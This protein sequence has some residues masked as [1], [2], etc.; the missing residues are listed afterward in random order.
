L[1]PSG[2]NF[3]SEFFSFF[4]YYQEMIKELGELA[5]YAGKS[6]QDIYFDIADCASAGRE[7]L[8]NLCSCRQFLMMG[9]FTQS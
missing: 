9:T 8:G 6:M 2:T 7:T 1:R 4:D 5:D 3:Y